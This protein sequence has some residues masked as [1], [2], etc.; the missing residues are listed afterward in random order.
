MATTAY[1]R[2]GPPADF[3]P[4]SDKGFRDPA[5]LY[6][7]ARKE[8]PVFWYEPLGVWIVTRRADVQ[9]ILIDWQTWSSSFEHRQDQGPDIPEPYDEVVKAELLR[10]MIVGLDPPRHTEVRQAAQPSFLRPAM[11]AIAPEIELR[12]HRIIDGF[13]DRGEAELMREYCLELTTETI[14]AL[15]DLGP[16]DA[17]MMRQLRFDHFQ[18]M[19]SGA[20]PMEEPRRT[21]VW[22]RY[23]AAHQR[24]REVVRER[25]DGRHGERFD[26]ISVMAA[27]RDKAGNPVLSDERVA[28]HVAEFAA[29]GTDTT[30]QAMANAVLFLAAYPEQ[31]AEAQADP[32]L[33]GAVFEETVRRRPSAPFAN[34]VATRDLKVAGVTIPKGERIWV[35]LASANTD[36]SSVGDPMTFNIH[37]DGL[38]NHLAFSKGRHNCIGAPLARAEGAAGLKVLYS[39]IPALRV[40][41][42]QMDFFPMALLP[43]R[44]SLHVTWEVPRR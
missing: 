44:Q 14:M 21:E 22:S 6:D 4:V 29:A 27:A 10:D 12:A 18:M 39:R 2:P 36:P 42:Q 26:V 11:K 19:A 28:L 3:D 32:E 9:A 20:E 37:R 25:R 43:M 16:E 34:R 17:A 30:A 35:A 31:L 1:E 24:L 5:S 8:R 7:L 41:E 13:I 40:P 15:L 38:S 33:W 23:A